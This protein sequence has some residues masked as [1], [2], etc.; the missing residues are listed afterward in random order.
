MK[1]KL[2]VV[3]IFLLGYSS[4]YA[5]SKGINFQS[6]VVDA[7]G[8]IEVSQEVDFK[9]DFYYSSD[10]STII[11]SETQSKTT[12]NKGLVSLLIGDGTKLSS[13]AELADLD[14]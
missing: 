3:L 6:I 1:N 7:S 10:L 9:F 2:L 14:W 13:G 4:V 5:Q 8:T 12:N 11:Y